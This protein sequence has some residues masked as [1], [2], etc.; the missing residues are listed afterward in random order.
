MCYKSNSSHYWKY[1]KKQVWKT[2]VTIQCSW[3]AYV[4]FISQKRNHLRLNL[5][6]QINWH[7][8][9]VFDFQHLKTLR[10]FFWYQLFASNLMVVHLCGLK[11][12]KKSLLGGRTCQQSRSRERHLLVPSPSPVRPLRFA[13]LHV[14]P[15]CLQE[16]K[17]ACTSHF[18]GPFV[19]INWKLV[20]GC[21]NYQ[22]QKTSSL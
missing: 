18:N 2:V 1:I 10:Y 15:V 13:P 11:I 4:A 5:D 19:V 9:P 7:W 21:G 20:I 16:W 12:R 17:T 22:L 6:S 14:R 3:I 8:V